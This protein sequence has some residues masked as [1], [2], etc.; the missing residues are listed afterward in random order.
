VP[1]CQTYRLP[2]FFDQFEYAVLDARGMD[3]R[4]LWESPDELVEEFFGA[5]LE[6]ERVAA[7]LDADIEELCD[8]SALRAVGAGRQPT[9]SA[10]KETF[11]LRWLTKFT[12]ATAASR[13]L[14]YKVR[15]EL[16]RRNVG[17]HTPSLSSH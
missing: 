14:G 1:R 6:V 5:Y 15:A 12:I 10:S 11:G 13:G 8:V 2:P 17:V 9:L 3:W 16:S 7:V 4:S